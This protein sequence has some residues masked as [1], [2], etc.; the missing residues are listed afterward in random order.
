MTNTAPRI[1][2]AEQDGKAIQTAP[3]ELSPIRYVLYARKSSEDDEGQALSIDSQV[4]EMLTITEHQ[5]IIVVETL[6]ERITP[7][8]IRTANQYSTSSLKTYDLACMTV[9]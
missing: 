3:V 7:S 5:D 6:T 2:P 1:L 8:S 9:L 4:K